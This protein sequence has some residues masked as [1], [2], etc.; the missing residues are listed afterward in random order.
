MNLDEL[1]KLR[2]ENFLK[3]KKKKKEYYLKKKVAKKEIDYENEL[4]DENFLL[5]IRK[6]AHDQKLYMDDRKDLIV[7][8]IN[9]YKDSKKEYYE[10]NKEK[11]LQYDKE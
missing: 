10:Q 4:S 9:E 11:R 5:K 1:K 8:K 6:I 2:E 3:H 7:K